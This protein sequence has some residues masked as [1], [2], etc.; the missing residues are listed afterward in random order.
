M[1]R[2]FYTAT[3]GVI[4]E[5]KNLT[6]RSNNIANVN[7]AGFKKDTPLTESFANM[8]LTRISTADSGVIGDGD[9][10]NISR[11]V[12]TD[13]TQGAFDET[14]RELDF[15]ILGEGYFVTQDEDGNRY[16]TR[17]GA[18]Y[19]DDEGYLCHVRG[20]QILSEDGEPIQLT[21]GD[22]FSVTNRG[23][24][25][26]DGAVV[27]QLAVATTEQPDTLVKVNEG[28]WAY[29]DDAQNAENAAV[30]WKT[31]ERSNVNITQEMSDVIAS[32]RHF[33]TCSQVMK[34]IDEL[35]QKTVTEIAKI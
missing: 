26:E 33:Q 31:L 28:L 18:F 5:N 23:E 17:D 29:P 16:L 6:V 8:L 2:S 14:G 24:I 21:D 3:S 9:F 1:I 20:G 35:T 12:S 19:L 7:T 13:Y 27:A 15:A 22:S 32:T 30:L 10:M 11:G 25:I 4:T 34:M